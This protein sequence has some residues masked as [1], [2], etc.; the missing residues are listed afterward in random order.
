MFNERFVGTTIEN[1]DR[2]TGYLTIEDGRTYYTCTDSNG[3][4]YET[5]EMP[6]V[7]IDLTNAEHL[8]IFLPKA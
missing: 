5:T 6:C 3:N 4:E 1:G 7:R 2:C 8:V